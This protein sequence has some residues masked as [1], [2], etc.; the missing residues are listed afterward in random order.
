MIYRNA[1]LCVNKFFLHRDK[2][3]LIV[4]I[5]KL[6][7]CSIAEEIYYNAGH[8]IIIDPNNSNAGSC[9]QDYVVPTAAFQY[10]YVDHQL[11]E[12]PVEKTLSLDEYVDQLHLVI[13]Q[14]VKNAY[15][16]DSVCFFYS[17]GIDS[18]VVLSYIIKLNLLGRTQ[19]FSIRNLTQQHSG[20]LDYH[21]NQFRL[22]KD[23]LNYLGV[24]DHKVIDVDINDVIYEFNQGTV[25]SF[26]TYVTSKL[27]R[28]FSNQNLLFGFHGNQILLHKPIYWNE[29]VRHRPEALKEIIELLNSDKKFYTTSVRTFDSE[30]FID[31]DY[32]HLLLKPWPA[33]DGLGGNKIHAPLGSAECFDL[34]RSLNFGT[35]GVEVISDATVARELIYRNTGSCLEQFIDC[36]S[37]G[38]IDSL[39][40]FSVPVNLLDQHS[41]SVPSTLRHHARGLHWIN[42]EIE[43]MHQQKTADPNTLA[44]IK[45]LQWLDQL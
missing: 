36:E 31:V 26:K 41:L 38:D 13:E 43:L 11:V 16:R 40:D 1:D 20:A 12:I 15:S 18:L 35:V 21:S 37:L 28:T 5:K 6:K 27:C 17:G 33:F 32:A 10:H 42:K 24:V 8:T 39:G 44:C 30:K 2:Q 29:I 14:S 45:T 25:D 22:I 3:Q 9:F 4:D 7:H 34:L 23:A 19:F